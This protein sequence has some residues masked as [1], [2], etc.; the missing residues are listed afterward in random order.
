MNQ[1]ILNQVAI[2]L[3]KA[4]KGILAADEST[5]TITKRFN[6][7]NVESSFENRRKYR[8]LLFKTNELNKFISG[9]ILYDE[10]IRQSTSE[11]V[12]FGKFLKEI[13][14]MPGIK[15]DTGAIPI[16]PGSLEKVTEGIDG[17]GERLKE[18][19][20]LGAVFTKW[21]AIIDIDE[22]NLVPSDY[23]IDLNSFNLAR[24][25]KNCSGSW[26]SPYC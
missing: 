15:V 1:T 12:P 21:R 18:Y 7:I 8:E 17:L 5:N 6:D 9:V 4:P 20:N 16:F 19:K 2:E 24:Y 23:A 22:N 10:T 25:A 26:I 14:I 13:G 11:K 3:S